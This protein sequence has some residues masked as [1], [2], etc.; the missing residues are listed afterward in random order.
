MS[1]KPFIP[2]TILSL[3]LITSLIMAG[4]GAATS[5]TDTVDDMFTDRDLS[6]EYDTS[7][8]EHITLSDTN[9]TISEEGVYVLSGSLADGQIIVAADD[10]AKVQLVLDQAHITSSNSAAIFVQS[11][12]KVFITLA[13]G[14]ENTLSTSGEY[15]EN[16]FHIDGVIFAKSD[17]TING[18]GS[19]TID[20]PYGH[21]IVSKDDLVIT[22]GTYSITA[23][24][25]ALSG[26][27]SIRIADGNFDLT[28]GSDG[29]HSDNEDD[30]EKG[31]VYIEDG[32][33]TIHAEDDGIHAGGFLWICNGTIDIPSCY[34]GLEGKNVTI[35]NGTISV[36]A[37]DDGINAAGGADESGMAG[38]ERFSENGDIY[39]TIN[40][41]DI[42]INAEGDGIDANGCLYFTGGNITIDGPTR[43]DNGALD[44]DGTA[45]ISGGIFI[46]VGS[47]RMAQNF[48]DASTQGCILVTL[49]SSANA[50]DAI[51]LKD[52]DG[53]TLLEFAPAKTYD[54][55]LISCP[56]IT[57]GSSYTI[58]AGEQEISVE[59]SSLIY[60]SGMMGGPGMMGDPGRMGGPGRMG[61]PGRMVGRGMMMAIDRKE[62]RTLKTLCKRQ[63]NNQ[64]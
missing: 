30:A 38:S 12:D 17:L 8:A 9:V 29:I 36:A 16:D 57:E 39:I 14:S 60:G 23:A 3:S 62:V 27:D 24:S 21:G 18:S 2:T 11:A 15:V 48:S 58:T 13:E 46:A 37:E 7:S 41:G 53:T 28:A 63:D 32:I 51:V 35:D 25:S 5:S 31:F 40:G 22:N 56:D 10:S 34:E 59:M 43:G 61:D 6:G 45:L 44:Y 64:K 42:S 4:C 26:K 52:S 47:S 50:G 20:S 19:L 33:F 55:I 1:F 54:S 49:E